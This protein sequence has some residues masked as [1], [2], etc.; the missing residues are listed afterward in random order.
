MMASGIQ[1]AS[2]LLQVVRTSSRSRKGEAGTGVQVF[3]E[4]APWQQPS[5][6]RPRP[7]AKL[8]TI[9]EEDYSSSSSSSITHGAAAAGS[10]QKAAPASSSSSSAAM[11]PSGVP[12]RGFVF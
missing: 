10:Q 7:P 2:F 5:A 8:D 6:G 3:S 12:G 1:R 11:V 4:A 9:V